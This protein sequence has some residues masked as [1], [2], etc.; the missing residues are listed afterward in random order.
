MPVFILGLD[1][2]IYFMYEEN[3]NKILFKKKQ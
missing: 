2:L 1:H 3:K